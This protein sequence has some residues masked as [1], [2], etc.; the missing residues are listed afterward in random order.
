MNEE[1]GDLRDGKLTPKRVEGGN[2]PAVI[3]DLNQPL[4]QGDERE[5][6]GATI[7]LTQPGEP[8]YEE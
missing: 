5:T 8:A 4:N 3:H 7:D 2:L 1:R 6:G